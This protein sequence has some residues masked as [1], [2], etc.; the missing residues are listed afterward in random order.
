[1]VCIGLYLPYN[2]LDKA[3]NFRED[4]IDLLQFFAQLN[5]RRF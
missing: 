2:G 5:L 3:V 4:L 1:M